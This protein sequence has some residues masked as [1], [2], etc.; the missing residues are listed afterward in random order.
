M[1]DDQRPPSDPDTSSDA[2]EPASAQAQQDMH[3]LLGELRAEVTRLKAEE[4]RAKAQNWIQRHPL[5]AVTLSMGV[6]AA[7]GYGVS[8]A[9]RPRPPRTL[10][11]R[12]RQRLRGLRG[13]ASELAARLRDRLRERAATSGAQLRERAE[14]T[15]R[16]L[17]E[18]AQQVRERAREEAGEVA[19]KASE[20]AR[21][22]GE[23]ASDRLR[24]ATDEA[25]RRLRERRADAADEAREL[26]EALGETASEAVEE[27]TDGEPEATDAGRPFARSLFALAGLAA[28]GYLAS[29]VRQWL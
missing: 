14:E 7:A 27:L 23:E 28:G 19:G 29:K 2:D 1:S 22:L 11:E 24:A 4:A 5:L 9:V 25:T 3:E 26:G 16:R 12:A 6:G 21:S 15:G 10:S 17:S 8:E 13:D 18:E 20:Q